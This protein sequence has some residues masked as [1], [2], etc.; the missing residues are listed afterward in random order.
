MARRPEEAV[1]E[2]S[3]QHCGIVV[4][5]GRAPVKGQAKPHRLPDGTPIRFVAWFMALGTY[6]RSGLS[7]VTP[8]LPLG[9]AKDASSRC[10]REE[11]GTL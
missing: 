6:A 9:S 1:W 5:E 10:R 4:R 8:A 3:R 2:S 7:E 11:R